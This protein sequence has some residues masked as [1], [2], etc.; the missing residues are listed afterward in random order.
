MTYQTK[1]KVEFADNGA[2]DAFGRLRVSEA[3]TIFDSKQLHDNDPLRWTEDFTGTGSTSWLAG[4]VATEL[5]VGEGPGNAVRQTKQ[6]FVYQP[7]RSILYNITGVMSR[8][9]VGP[10]AVS[11]IGAFDDN[12][13]VYFE[14][15]GTMPAV[16]MYSNGSQVAYADRNSWNVDAFDG[17][18]PSG[19]D[20]DF[21]KALIF[22][23]DFQWLG[24]G[25]VRMG[26]TFGRTFYPCHVFSHANVA[27]GVYMVNPNLPVRYELDTPS[28]G[29]NMLAICSSV[30]GESIVSPAG[31]AKSIDR[32][33]TTITA[34]S[35]GDFV[36]LI[37]LRLK[38]THLNA[39]VIPTAINVHSPT[40]ANFLWRL[41]LNPTI[42]GTDAASWVPLA[43]SAVEYDIS[44]TNTNLISGG[45]V[46]FSDYGGGG[47]PGGQGSPAQPGQ[48]FDLQLRLGSDLQGVRD[49]Y[50]LAAAPI[51]GINQTLIG[52]IV[53]RELL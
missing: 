2:L 33:I 21:T 38:S 19:I 11:R 4:E 31:V 5:S 23:I 36:P 15:A 12:D 43:N 13:G 25:D 17:S 27:S 32:G 37:S 48:T 29:R 52:N 18:G 35:A 51:S 39:A 44:R 24:V 49:E 42:A 45:T 22:T 40:S 30:S 6:R 20:L 14:L 9:S 46:L 50:I 16:V 8:Y 26:F 1:T 28:S 3:I 34:P 10:D 7:G 47:V 41:Y 53:F